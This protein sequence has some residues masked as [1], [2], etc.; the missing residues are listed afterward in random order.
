MAH[1][2]RELRNLDA[3]RYEYDAGDDEDYDDVVCP[4]CGSAVRNPVNA[5]SAWD[6]M[7]LVHLGLFYHKFVLPFPA[8]LPIMQA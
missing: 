6:V 8:I 3:G 1:N 4:R 2:D 7:V 5:K